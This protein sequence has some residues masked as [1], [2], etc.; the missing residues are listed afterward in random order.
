MNT[1]IKQIAIAT[2]AAGTF[3]FVYSFESMYRDLKNATPHLTFTRYQAM[4][5]F[6]QTAVMIAHEQNETGQKASNE[7]A[8]ELFEQNLIAFSK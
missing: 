8:L 7:R 4:L 5:A 2:V 6:G 1:V 3:G